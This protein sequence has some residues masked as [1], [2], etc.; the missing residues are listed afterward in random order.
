MSDVGFGG[1]VSMAT[2]QTLLSNGA[3]PPEANTPAPGTGGMAARDDHKHPRLSSATVQSLDANGE[4]VV[5]FT[6]AF[7]AMPAVPAVRGKRRAAGC[8]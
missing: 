4:A 1:V 2:L 8:L 6:R 7:A 5:S 3:P